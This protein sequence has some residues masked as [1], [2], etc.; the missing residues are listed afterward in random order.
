MMGVNDSSYRRNDL[1]SGLAWPESQ[2]TAAHWRCSAFVMNRPHCCNGSTENAGPENKGPMTEQMD[3][4]PTD[5]TWKW[6]PNFQGRKIQDQKMR[7][8][9][10]QDWQC[11]TD[12]T[13]LGKAGP[14]NAGV[15]NAEP[16]DAGLI[17]L[18]HLNRKKRKCAVHRCI[19][20]ILPVSYVGVYWCCHCCI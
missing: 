20:F 13:G 8:Q 18:H 9:K 4:R 5:T 2:S 3:E 16:E 7:D 10:I 12:N 17:S 6:G 11:R 19:T 1:P 14:K 15:E